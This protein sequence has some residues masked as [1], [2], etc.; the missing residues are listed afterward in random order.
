MRGGIRTNTDRKAKSLNP[1]GGEEH[2][3]RCED[4]LLFNAFEPVKMHCRWPPCRFVH[5]L[6]K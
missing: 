1:R 6:G 2:F 3:Y 5:L 4:E